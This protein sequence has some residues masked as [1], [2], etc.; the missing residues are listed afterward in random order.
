MVLRYKQLERPVNTDCSKARHIRSDPQKNFIW[1]YCCFPLS[2]N[3]VNKAECQFYTTFRVV[4]KSLDKGTFSMS[5]D[6]FCLREAFRGFL[7][8]FSHFHM[9]KFPNSYIN[10]DEVL[11]NYSVKICINDVNIAIQ[12][13]VWL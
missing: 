4:Y 1:N 12:F 7:I 8:L 11:I 13:L 2:Q 10:A 9:L 5:S 6:M 3:L